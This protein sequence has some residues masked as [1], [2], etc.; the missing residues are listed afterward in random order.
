[1]DYKEKYLKYKQKYLSLK[2][3]LG[4]TKSGI[5]ATLASL[6]AAAAG[7]AGAASP[8]PVAPATSTGALRALVASSAAMGTAA[9]VPT[10][11]TVRQPVA[12]AA[13]SKRALEALAL[14]SLGTAN[15]TPGTSVTLPDTNTNRSVNLCSK[16]ICV[17]KNEFGFDETT[18]KKQYIIHPCTACDCLGFCDNSDKAFTIDPEFNI[19]QKCAVCDHNAL[20]HDIALMPIKLGPSIKE[21]EDECKFNEKYKNNKKYIEDLYK[22]NQENASNINALCANTRTFIE[23]GICNTKEIEAD[24]TTYG[25]G[26]KDKLL[27]LIKKHTEMITKF[28][29]TK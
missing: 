27:P 12:P 24:N 23:T 3:Q 28:N 2:Q 29:A 26:N 1:M 19:Y 11:A 7:V 17:S 25:F 14:A 5:G 18:G 13:S 9:S 22:S 4:G 8:V 21:G 15:I 10:T 20:Q 6:G 16:N